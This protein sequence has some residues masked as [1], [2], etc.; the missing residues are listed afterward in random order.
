M[1]RESWTLHIDPRDT[2]PVHEIYIE[3]T[4][5]AAD[6]LVEVRLKSGASG[7]KRLPHIAAAGKPLRVHH[8]LDAPHP[9]DDIEITFTSTT[10]EAVRLALVAVRVMGQTEELREHVLRHVIR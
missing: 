1:T 3:G 9:T 8:V 7:L 4:P 6:L 2:A 10:G 5:P